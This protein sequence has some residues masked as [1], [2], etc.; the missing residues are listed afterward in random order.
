MFEMEHDVTKQ[1]QMHIL[2]GYHTNAFKYKYLDYFTHICVFIEK[3]T[4]LALSKL[5]L[6]HMKSKQNLLIYPSH[7]DSY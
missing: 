3:I 1:C 7:E 6:E 2:L 5:V 4:T